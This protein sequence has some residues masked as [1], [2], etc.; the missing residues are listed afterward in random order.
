MFVITGGSRGIG[1]ALAKSLSNQGKQVL[2]VGRDERTLQAIAKNTANIQICVADV[3]IASGRDRI[4]KYL[5]KYHEI[6]SLIHNAGT[7]DPIA[8]MQSLSA[9][10]WQ[11]V[12]NLNLSAPFF[13]TQ[14]LYSKLTNGRV[15]HM[16]S[17][18]AH[19]PV[20]GWAPYCASK[21]ALAMLTRSWQLEC[22]EIATASVM[23]GIVATEMQAHI[24]AAGHQ[25]PDKQ[26]FFQDLHDN[27]RLITP[28]TVA[29]FLTWL[30]LN[31]NKTRYVSQEWD[32]YDV[33]H[34]VEW[35]KPPHQVPAL[36]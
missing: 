30:L 25:H 29:S 18:A 11:H 7:I 10:A 9:E 5:D 21:A 32:I 4:I 33:S 26:Q 12:M 31:I 19:F 22:P 1:A 13:L 20:Q 35:L 17:G 28:D 3:S 6:T 2:I 14:A 23:P 16:G 34:H 24:R 8:P 15:L 36:D 27:N